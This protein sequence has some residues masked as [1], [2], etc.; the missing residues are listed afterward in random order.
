MDTESR[1]HLSS[2]MD[3]EVSQETG[4]FLVRRLGA[5]SELRST[6]ARYHLI[7]DCMRHQ[8]GELAKEDLTSRVQQALASEPE[9]SGGGSVRQGWFKPVMG[10]A[11][12]ASVALVAVMTVS[13]QN[14]SVSPAGSELAQPV[15][16]ESF[17]SPNIGSVAPVTQPVNLSGNAGRSNPK[18]NTYLL[19]HYQVSGETGGKGFV[20]FVPIVVAPANANIDSDQESLDKDN[21]SVKQ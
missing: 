9:V 7:R 21:E 19:R 20:S 3:G 1:E 2:L 4:R 5:D 6:W 16:S 13:Q 18:M 12:A 17:T 8:E 14:P 11:I 15:V 10:A